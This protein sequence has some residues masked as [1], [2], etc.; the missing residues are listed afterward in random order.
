MFRSVTDKVNLLQ[1]HSDII[2][3][4]GVVGIVLLLIIPLQPV[5]LDAF[6]SVSIVLAITTLLI[7]IYTREALEFNA[8]PSLL[9]FVTLFRLG[10]N[11]ASTRMILS[12]GKAGDIIKTFGEFV[13]GG[14]LIVGIVIFTLLTVIN[15][16][17]ITKGSGRIA[18]VAARFTLDSMPGKQMAIDADINA[19]IIDDKEAVVRREKVHAEADFYGAMDGAS[20]F[21]RGDA[22]AGVII[23]LVN[24]VGGLAIG[25]A[26]KGMSWQ[27]AL[28]T[29]T[30]LTIGD[31]LISQ[32]PALL[33]S[34]GAGVIVTRA[35]ASESLGK[36]I[37]NQMF[38]NPKILFVTA[39]MVT[40]LGLLP[41][42]PFIVMF[43]IAFAVALYGYFLN[44]NAKG[45]LESFEAKESVP[46][47]PVERVLYVDAM[48][49]ELGY[50]L[51]YM[52]DETKKD[53][54]VQKINDIRHDTAVE[55]GFVIPAIRIKDNIS[56]EAENYLIK[57]KGIEVFRGVAHDKPIALNSITRNLKEIIQGHAHELISRQ[58]VS[59][60]IDNVK[61]YAPALVEELI[62]KQ[63]S[64][65]QVLK[66]L[67][68]LLGE[69]IP[70][71]DIVSILE[72]LADNSAR[73]KDIDVLTEHV[74]QNLSRVISKKYTDNVGKMYAIT[75]DPKVEQM[76]NESI[77]K[78][79]Y[80]SRV[81]LRPATK[82]KI[83][84]EIDRC[85]HKASASGVKP[86]VLTSPM[87][88][89][90]FK[91]LIERSFIGLPVSSY[92]EIVADTKIE[93][94][95]MVP[96]EVLI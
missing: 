25:L 3:S 6:L 62:P 12:E 13:T 39:G 50:G 82:Q 2:M 30:T 10:L 41:G 1:K 81:V 43:P 37:A 33:I 19:G 72:N 23:T 48:E 89:I 77:Q 74:R 27:S 86:V 31:G 22:I 70:I 78:S 58:D 29:Y 45:D 17:V 28:S 36:T 68:N 79:E 61:E 94:I 38:N 93:T 47:E 4:V 53:N 8:F 34:V 7:T 64:L 65:G 66:V 73:I 40:L 49:V 26:V 96:P 11:I 63:M 15:F 59:K 46:E 69:G 18:E 24:L 92:H 75:L 51:L 67:R 90:H 44:R 56:L 52:L 76:I 5:L 88:R 95:G 9:L 35:S 60:L 84:Q 57:I 80:G 91:R 71:R 42:M 14:S 83:L 32:I 87:V 16:V 20:K 55:L 21:V 85:I 54:L